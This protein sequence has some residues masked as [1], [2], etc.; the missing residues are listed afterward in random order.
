[1]PTSFEV[2]VKSATACGYEIAT[3]NDTINFTHPNSKTRRGRVGKGVAQTLDCACNQGVI[4]AKIKVIG[5]IY[6]SGHNSGDIF[7]T[8]GI[9]GALTCSGVRPS[10]KNVAPKIISDFRIRRLTPKECFRLM[11]MRDEDIILVN[12]DSQSYKIAGNG[13]EINTMRS[14]L[15][16]LY[17]PVKKVG[18]LF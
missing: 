15:K 17:K 14:I 1:L 2:G 16:Q 8:N 10:V 11:G 5:N 13:I 18:S 12:S 3:E 6:D 9:I 4:E 7:D